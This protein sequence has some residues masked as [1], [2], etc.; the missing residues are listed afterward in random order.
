MDTRHRSSP[1]GIP[2]G[3]RPGRSRRTAAT[4]PWRHKPTRPRPAQSRAPG[5]HSR[6]PG[7]C[8]VGVVD[9]ASRRPQ[10][11]VIR[12]AVMRVVL[13]HTA[14]PAVAPPTAATIATGVSTA[15]STTAPTIHTTATSRTDKDT[16]V[17][18]TTPTTAIRDAVGTATTT[19]TANPPTTVDSSDRA[20]VPTTRRAT[21]RRFPPS[22]TIPRDGHPIPAHA[23]THSPCASCSGLSTADP[24]AP[25]RQCPG[26]R[27]SSPNSPPPRRGDTGVIGGGGTPRRGS[28]LG[29]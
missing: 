26:G 22:T 3:R 19:V 18:T 5:A 9:V 12:T 27:G 16:A 7:D 14:A 1:S 24:A 2:S 15:A 10:S 25:S 11:T 23:P 17:A 21:H 20:T 6:A 13:V 8:D 4:R 29:Q 28:R